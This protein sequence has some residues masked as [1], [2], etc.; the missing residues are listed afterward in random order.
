VRQ[1]ITATPYR[2]TLRATVPA[3]A[4][5]VRARLP[6]SIPA[7]I[8]PLDEG[9]C[10]VSLGADALDELTRDVVT[11]GPGTRLDASPDVLAHL[12]DVGRWLLEQG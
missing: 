12:R 4:E 5:D 7:R 11:L 6:M 10:A 8:Q 9:S 1:T 2:Y 3:P